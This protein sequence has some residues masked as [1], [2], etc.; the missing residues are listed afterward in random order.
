MRNSAPM[1]L[2]LLVALLGLVPAAALANH[3]LNAHTVRANV[4]GDPALERVAAEK[5]RKGG[6]DYRQVVLHDDCDGLDPGWVLS[7]RH[8][9]V[10]VMEVREFD[11]RSTRPEIY[12]EARSGASGRAGIARLYA[13]V[14][15]PAGPPTSCSLPKKLFEYS[16][17]KPR[18]RP[19]EGTWVAGFGVFVK[20]YERSSAALEFRVVE[21]LA[22]DEKP[23]VTANGSRTSYWRLSSGKYVRYRTRTTMPSR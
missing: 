1:R 11:G 7:P 18:P 20:N 21:N 16:T 23:A 4:D 13:Y 3:N 14:T 17:A 12:L 5:V 22:F 19:P 8:D 9:I 2:P 15:D 6:I 10:P